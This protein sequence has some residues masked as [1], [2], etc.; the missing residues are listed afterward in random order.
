DIEL[1]V[2]TT[3]KN[4][5]VPYTGEYYLEYSWKG[6]FLGDE[7]NASVWMDTTRSSCDVTCTVSAYDRTTHAFLDSDTVSWHAE[8]DDSITV[9]VSV[10]NTGSYALGDEDVK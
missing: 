2:S 9:E 8:L 5:D 10:Y 3:L 6:N 7:E 4:G 1:S